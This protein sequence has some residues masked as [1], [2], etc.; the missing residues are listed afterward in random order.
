[1]RAAILVGAASCAVGSVVVPIATFDGAQGTTLPWSPVNDPVMGGQSKS[2]FEVD[3]SGNVGVWNG[4]V[5]IVPFLGAPGFCTLQA[6]GLRRTLE[7]PDLTGTDGIIAQLRQTLPDGLT[8]FSMQLRTKGASS[9]PEVA[10]M[11]NLTAIS[12]EWNDYFVPWSAFICTRRGQVLPSCPALASQLKE[13]SSVGIATVFP[14][15]PGPFNIE[16]GSIMAGPPKSAPSRPSP[17]A[18]PLVT[19]D[20][21][22]AHQWTS[23]NDPVMGGQ[24]SSQFH[25]EQGYG[26]YSGVCRIVPKLQAPG[27]TIALTENPLMGHFPDVSGMDGLLLSVRR[28][29]GNISSFK[30]AFCD[31]RINLFRC[32]FGTFKAGFEVP[33]VSA[34]FQDIFLPWS[35]FSDKWSASTGQHT[36]EE[37]PTKSSLASITQLQLWTEGVAGDFH[38][39]VQS[40]AAAKAS[41]S[42]G[43]APSA[44]ES[45]HV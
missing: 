23:E 32:Q 45:L 20:G 25:A 36:A 35:A 9:S 43:V 5:K 6:P 24:S 18:I 21:A 34:N 8:G 19:F 4:E 27:F 37:P 28:A 40:I 1:M 38:L 29:G 14:G 22:A 3:L 42:S 10:Y 7:F 17:E 33:E 31:S 15:K 13:I 2:T 16:I 30:V 12:A 41:Q 26:D 39:Q 11:A 44:P